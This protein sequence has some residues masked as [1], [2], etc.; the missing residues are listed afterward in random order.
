MVAQNDYSK[1]LEQAAASFSPEK[2]MRDWQQNA[3][4]LLRAQERILRGIA[5]AAQ[6]EISYGQEVLSTRLALLHGDAPKPAAAGT[7][8]SA[9]ME[10]LVAL[11]KEVSD[12]LRTSFTEAMQL[13]REGELVTVNDVILPAE[14]AAPPA[15]P[16]LVTPE[17]PKAESVPEAPVAQAAPPPAKPIPAKPTIARKPAPKRG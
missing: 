16:D 11:M 17:A 7:Q 3:T 12:E 9:E 5:G 14:A 6:L 4:R 2:M 10:K 15:K 13:L 8:V 1:A